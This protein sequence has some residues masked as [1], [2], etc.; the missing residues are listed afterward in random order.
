MTKTFAHT[1]DATPTPDLGLQAY[2]ATL[3]SELERFG[4]LST[5]YNRTDATRTYILATQLLD[6]VRQLN[7][8]TRQP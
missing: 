4:W 2:I 5:A 7:D 6:Y 8:V 3:K 1:P